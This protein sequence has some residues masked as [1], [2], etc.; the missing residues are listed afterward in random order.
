MG[1]RL[2]GGISIRSGKRPVLQRRGI[3]GAAPRAETK[4]FYERKKFGSTPNALQMAQYSSKRKRLLP[5]NA[6][7]T[8]EA[9]N[10]V[11]LHK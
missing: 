6:K 2:S 1:T 11:R 5:R 7:L 10:P 9:L 4:N 3:P 8:A